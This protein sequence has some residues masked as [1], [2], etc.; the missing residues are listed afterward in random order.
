MHKP[1]PPRAESRR[2]QKR[3][4][5]EAAALAKVAAEQARRLRHWRAQR[6]LWGYVLGVIAQWSQT[7]PQYRPR[8][9]QRN[10]DTPAYWRTRLLHNPRGR[11]L[12]RLDF[13]ELMDDARELAR[14][15]AELSPHGEKMLCALYLEHRRTKAR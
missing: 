6:G 1:L 10:T 3:Q 11:Q 7:L 15:G 8:Y 14:L 13:G 5:K 9:P 4:A 12:R 2:E